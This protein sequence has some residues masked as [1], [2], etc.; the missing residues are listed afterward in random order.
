MLAI[1]CCGS[2]CVISSNLALPVHVVYVQHALK[3]IVE[4]SILQFA[5]C[6]YQC[7]V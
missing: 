6:Y 4:I 2:E 1:Q 7:A 5:V 3:L